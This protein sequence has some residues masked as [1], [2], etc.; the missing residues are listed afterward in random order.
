M[1]NTYGK[2]A[3]SQIITFG[4]M[5]AKAVVRDVARVQDKPYA[6]A[7]KM[8]KLIPFEVGMTL[9]KAIDQ[10]EQLVTLL[11]EDVAAQEIWDMAVQLEGLTR[12]AGKHAGGVVIA[13]SQLTDFHRCSATRRVVDLSPSSTRTTLKKR[14]W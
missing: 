12:N 4:T 14:A 13:P 9:A 11:A 3:V 2:A 6:L 8:S 10:E 5:A 7:D 1:S